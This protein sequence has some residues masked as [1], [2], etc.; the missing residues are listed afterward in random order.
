VG[1]FLV[2]GHRLA[3]LKVVAI[4]VV[5]KVAIKVVF[6]IAVNIEHLAPCQYYFGLLLF[7][8]ASYDHG[9]GDH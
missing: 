8:Q 3:G 2:V 6:L 5:I 4:K 9:R 7:A 1:D